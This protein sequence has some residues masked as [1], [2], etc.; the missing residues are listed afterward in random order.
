MTKISRQV[1]RQLDRSGPIS[2]STYRPVMNKSKTYTP[3]GKREVARRKGNDG[4]V[5]PSSDVVPTDG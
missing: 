1:R 2:L 3:N 5:V 4:L